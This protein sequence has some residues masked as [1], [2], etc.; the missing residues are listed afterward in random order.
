MAKSEPIFAWEYK[1]PGGQPE[2]FFHWEGMMYEA[3]R[4]NMK[5]GCQ[6]RHKKN[7][8]NQ[9][10]PAENY[11]V[12]KTYI[13]PEGREKH[14]REFAKI[15]A[16]F[17]APL[18][19]NAEVVDSDGWLYKVPGA[20]EEYPRNYRSDDEIL[21]E[22]SEGRLT[23][24]CLVW[25]LTKTQGEWIPAT[26]AG[27]FKNSLGAMAVA[28]LEVNTTLPLVNSSAPKV[29]IAAPAGWL[30]R[31]KGSHQKP[32]GYYSDQEIVKECGEGCLTEKCEVW[33]A[34]HTQG[35][36]RDARRIKAF[37]QRF[38][39]SAAFQ[40]AQYLA[41]VRARDIEAART[42][43]E[44]EAAKR[45]L[46]EREAEKAH[47]ESTAE[48]PALACKDKKGRSWWHFFASSFTILGRT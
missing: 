4:G 17:S 11:S 23:K 28:H 37:A 38:Q 29:A 3:R 24:D 47:G 45:F 6:I 18:I 20:N 5:V 16:I 43:E 8:K 26:Q 15:S 2:G 46:A 27:L 42:S 36:W 14:A 13:T 44:R 12:F 32:R 19:C 34:R 30:Y 21:I 25:H 48:D 7:T 10:V 35:E 39:T 1:N 40:R 41:A 9:W 22:V 31:E 33:H